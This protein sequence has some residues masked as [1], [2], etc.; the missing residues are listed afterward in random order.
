MIE[1]YCVYAGTLIF[2]FLYSSTS[3]KMIPLLALLLAL[4]AL[5]Q[6][7]LTPCYSTCK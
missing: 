7:Q 4:L 6:A 5:A 3:F 2:L 1:C